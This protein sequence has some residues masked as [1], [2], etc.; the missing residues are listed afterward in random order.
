M[1]KGRS[2]YKAM[3]IT[4]WCS[5][6]IHYK[7]GTFFMSSATWTLALGMH[8][9][10]KFLD[11]LVYRIPTVDICTHSFQQPFFSNHLSIAL[12]IGYDEILLALS[13]GTYQDIFVVELPE[14]CSRPCIFQNLSF[15]CPGELS[16]SMLFQKQFLPCLHSLSV[17]GSTHSMHIFR[18]RS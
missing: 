16:C 11:N 6:G 15:S 12:L 5:L 4:I 1:Q 18:Q 3:S 14:G 9:C 7:P 8:V 13:A 17:H 2:C 10:W